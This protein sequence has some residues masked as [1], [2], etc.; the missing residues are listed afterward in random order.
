M[1]SRDRSPRLRPF[2]T[3]LATG[4]LLALP[5]LA[6]AEMYFPPSLVSDD[7]EA[8][9]DLSHLTPAGTQLP[10]T[11]EVQVYLNGN[12]LTARSVRFV[13]A[14]TVPPPSTVIAGVLPGQ[15]IR[16]PT[17]LMACL[18]KTDWRD[19]GL[20]TDAVAALSPVA[21]EQCLSPGRYIPQAYT[22][23][24]FEQMRLDISLPQ[25]IVKNRPRGWISPERWDEGINALM[26]GYRFNGSNSR[27]DYS[28]SNNHFLSLDNGLNL[29]PWRL[30]DTRSWSHYSSSRGDTRSR[31]E[32]L[33]TYAER[34]IIPLRSQLLLGESSTDGELFDA[35]SFRGAKLSTDEGMYPDNQRGFAP[36]VKGV[37]YSNARV[38]IRQNGSLIYQTFVP[39]GA[40]VIDDLHPVSSGGDLDVTVTE[41]DGTPRTFTVPYSSVPL[42]Q[43][44]GRVRWSVVAG[45]FRS[46]S[47]RYDAPEFAQGTVQ[48]GLPYDTTVYGGT[49]V[50]EKYRAGLLGAGVNLGRWGGM[51]ADFTHASSE[52]ADKSRHTGQSVRFLYARSMS[53]LGTTVRLAGYRYSTRGFHTLSETAL[54]GM[55]GWLYDYDEVDA[56]G[57]PV[58]RPYTDYYNLYD[59]K[60]SRIQAN[61]SQKL[62][63]LGSLYVTGTR[64]TYWKNNRS[65][66]SLTAGYSGALGPV[67]YNLSWSYSKA[68]HQ[69]HS[70]RMGWLSFSLPFSALMP[71]HSERP[72]VTRLTGNMSRSS[73]GRS[74]Y[75]AGASGALLDDYNLNWSVQQ[76]YR[77]EGTSGGRN[78]NSGNAS[79]NY[80]GTYGSTTLGY[81]HSP[82][83]RQVNYGLTG[84]VVIHRNG[85][86]L[87]QQPGTTSVL[88]AAPGAAGVPVMNGSGVKTDWRGY[89]LLPYSSEYRET[90]I[91][92]DASGLD[93]QTE[94]E[95]TSVRVVPTRG[96]LVRAAFRASNGVRA[97]VRMTR[98]GKP[99]PFG[100]TVT[101]GSSSGITGDN[102]VVYLTGLETAGELKA[103]WGNGAHQTCTVQYRLTE[104]QQQQSP[105][106]LSGVCVP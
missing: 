74:S 93:E 46:N 21:E 57:R 50:A 70:D 86:T 36:M 43:R 31:W 41:A 39:P 81:S 32:R 7:P 24:D 102:G 63:D 47:H 105:V 38:S 71:G 16:D 25:A 65:T 79:L 48:W 59:T 34:A 88:V 106:S 58:Q 11:Y 95:E 9:A 10:G 5:A 17:G 8:V 18:T 72:S 99:L 85:V 98:D 78:G 90:T 100:T 82:G 60:R 37:A 42:L 54:K 27:G 44:E 51:S 22:A 75:M 40:F 14:G 92:L 6:G 19:I 67:N 33:N 73:S 28:N 69:P 61:V 53:S 91:S 62:G 66:D 13:V 55:T 3:P 2:L 49:Q 97:L 1:N 83:T 101:A 64:Q 52:L 96:A 56:E 29:G 35:F 89:A 23:F 77:R 80:R 20:K 45:R 84:G 103:Q 94:L 15:D 4:L 104:E 87:G 76:G 26:L 68:S 12:W 30:R